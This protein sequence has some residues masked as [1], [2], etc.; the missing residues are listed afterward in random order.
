MTGDVDTL[1]L[2]E[3]AETRPRSLIRKP[4]AVAELLARVQE[5]LETGGEE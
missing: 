5:V 2:A 1:D 4:F 3:I